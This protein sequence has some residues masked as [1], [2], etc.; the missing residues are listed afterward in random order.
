M[1]ILQANKFFY[2]KGGSERYMFAL[3]RSLESL[4][5]RIV[6]FSMAHPQN[7]PCAQSG[8]FVP[9]RDYDARNTGLDSV[10]AV[11]NFVRSPRAARLLSRLLAD[12]KPDVAHLHNIYHQLTPSIIDVLHEN[13]VPMVMTLHDYKLVCPSYTMFARG[14]PCYRCRG[15]RFH[16]AVATGC[17]G[18]RARCALLALESYWQ[19]W[20][21]VYDRVDCFIAPSEY[22]RAVMVDAGVAADR[23]VHVPQLSPGRVQG[24]GYPANGMPGLEGLPGRFIAYAGRLSA[25]KGIDILI[26]AMA[27]LR[28]V[29]LV[30]FGEGPQEQRLRAVASAQRL[31]NV[32][33]AGHVSRPVVDGALRRSAALV[34]PS[35]WAE[36][37]PMVIM[38]AAS[39]GVPVIVSDRGGLPELA[40]EVSGQVVAAGDVPALAEAIKRVWGNDAYWKEA[41]RDAWDRNRA[42]HEPDTHA[43]TIAS[44]YERMIKERKSN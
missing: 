29:P 35:L 31:E 22:L 23:V 2:E 27:L 12:T 39:A 8:Y 36:N 16:R 14:E 5:H 1:I 43:R 18:S 19:R 38:E 32:I 26:R 40:N 28:D 25:E 3:S 11:M 41:A 44:L 30:V 10:S 21:R 4:G 9:R 34:V 37:A 33:F 6:S 17:A 13:R 24:D 42:R 15:G 20:T 7:E